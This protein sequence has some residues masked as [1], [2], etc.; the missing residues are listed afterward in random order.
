[1]ETGRVL[2]F[3]PLL[4][5]KLNISGGKIYAISTTE[6]IPAMVTSASECSAGWRATISVPIPMNMISADRMI[7]CL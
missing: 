6:N 7:E 1:M 5:R 3:P 4:T 2:Y